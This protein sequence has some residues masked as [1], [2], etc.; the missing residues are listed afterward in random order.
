MAGDDFADH[1]G[2]LMLL[3]CVA[4]F[5]AFVSFLVRQFFADDRYIG[6]G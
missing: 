3:L 4:K 5:L 1:S 2:R 6:D